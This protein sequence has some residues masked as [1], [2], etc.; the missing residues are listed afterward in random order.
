M[1]LKATLVKRRPSFISW[2]AGLA[3]WGGIVAH[4][5]SVDA[6]PELRVSVGPSSVSILEDGR[7][8]LEYRC[9]GAAFK[10]FVKELF[11]PAGVN[12]LRDAPHD[13][14]HHHG[15]MFALA[16]E[17]V[18]FWE[19]SDAAGRQL[20]RSINNVRSETDGSGALAAF[21]DQLEWFAPDDRLLLRERRTIEIHGGK[22]IEGLNATLLTWKTRLEP[23]P[24]V[25]DMTLTGSH[26]HGLGARFVASMDNVGRFTNADGKGGKIFRGDE[27]LVRS[28]WCAYTAM[29]NDNAVTVAMFDHPANV[30]HPATWFTMKSPFAYLAAT[31]RLHEQTLTLRATEGL[32]LRYGVAVW[33]GQVDGSQIERLYRLWLHRCAAE[34]E[35]R[36]KHRIRDG[37]EP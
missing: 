17:G 9:Q 32:E 27:R 18:N 5:T 31:L 15:L 2:A 28:R 34:S 19:E 4:A 16:V 25:V 7:R 13:H 26:Y 30:R 33:D 21:S 11:T 35:A 23:A 14:L 29:V 1:L 36:S 12:V 6:D 22:D 8:V 20:H 24:G 37:L 3:L 10:P